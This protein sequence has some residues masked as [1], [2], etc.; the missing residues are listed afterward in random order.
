MKINADLSA[1]LSRKWRCVGVTAGLYFSPHFSQTPPP[2]PP[3]SMTSSIIFGPRLATRCNKPFTRQVGN[4]LG[5]GESFRNRL[6]HTWSWGQRNGNPVP[7]SK[8]GRMQTKSR[9]HF[10]LKLLKVVEGGAGKDSRLIVGFQKFKLFGAEKVVIVVFHFYFCWWHFWDGPGWWREF[11]ALLIGW[12]YGG[13]ILIFK[14]VG[15]WTEK[16]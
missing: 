2:P 5:I 10:V 3:N 8:C 16:C 14:M 1:A 11:D 9:R 13:D 12:F 6:P 4:S 15:K 7:T